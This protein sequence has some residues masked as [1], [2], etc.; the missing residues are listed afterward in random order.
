MS[1]LCER[2]RPHCAQRGLIK[3]EIKKWRRPKN[4]ILS[5]IA[6]KL[7]QSTQNHIQM[8]NSKLIHIL[9]NN[10]VQN[11]IGSTSMCLGLGLDV[12]FCQGV[13]KIKKFY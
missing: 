8:L 6:C 5:I 3:P 4:A 7:S 2:L 11:I 12:I 9:L 10:F 1:A 13:D